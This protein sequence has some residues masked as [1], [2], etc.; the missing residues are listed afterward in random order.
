MQVRTYEYCT[1]TQVSSCNGMDEV[2]C[3]V[4]MYILY[5]TCVYFLYM[6]CVHLVRDMHVHFVRDMR[7]HLVRDMR[8]HLVRDMHVHFVRDMH[9]HLCMTCVYILYMTCTNVLRFKFNCF[10]Y[11]CSHLQFPWRR[12]LQ[13][14][15]EVWRCR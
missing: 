12:S 2:Q 4:R 9:V 14:I 8:V 6:T 15:L 13:V 3:H 11:P 1:Y 7:V 10:R 5:V